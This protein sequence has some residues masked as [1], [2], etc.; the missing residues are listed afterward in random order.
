MT[1]DDL[2]KQLE[3]TE[4][5]LANQIS[6]LHSEM[7]HRFD[8]IDKRFD[9]LEDYLAGKIPHRTAAQQLADR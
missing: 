5:T 2:A 9:K 1:I 4:N 3:T 6:D 8:A 7:N